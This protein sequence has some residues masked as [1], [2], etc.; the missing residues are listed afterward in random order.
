MHRP[1]RLIERIATGITPTRTDTVLAMVLGAGTLVQAALTLVDPRPWAGAVIVGLVTCA[2][3][4]WR[5]RT[6]VG[7]NAVAIAA[8]VVGDLLGLVLNGQATAN[9][10]PTAAA[11]AILVLTYSGVRYAEGNWRIAVWA[12]WMVQALADVVATEDGLAYGL[13]ISS[14]LAT[15]GAAALGL[16]FAYRA[17]LQT[18]RDTEARTNER[19]TLARELHDTV[20]HHVSAMVVQATAAL[21][22]LDRQPEQAR[23]ALQFIKM[24]GQETMGE[25]RRMVGILRGA[26]A[27][28]L[29]PRQGIAE[30]ADLFAELPGPVPV[31]LRVLGTPVRVASPVDQ[32][33]HRIAQE[34]VTNARRHGRQST[35]IDVVVRWA[36]DELVLEVAN[37]GAPALDPGNAAGGFGLVG[38]AERTRLLGGTFAAGPQPGGGWRVMTR[39]PL[40][41]DAETDAHEATPCD[42]DER[43]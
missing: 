43:P 33:V 5:R 9:R 7:S 2:A 31:H 3:V 39:L 19:E 1:R 28:E 15:T 40:E 38:M 25:M 23:P 11:F 6:P 29:C 30:L 32:S 41:P 13:I 20:A 22:V 35:A 24:S 16:A 14:W 21:A 8:I 37:D 27:A 26:E 10:L 42:P 36:P 4:A 34:S 17:D 12:A 18:Q